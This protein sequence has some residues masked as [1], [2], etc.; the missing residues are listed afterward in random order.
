MSPG[1]LT[2]LVCRGVNQRNATVVV[3]DSL[4]GYLQA[5]PQESFLALEIHQ[6]LSYLNQQRVLTILVTAQHG[7]VGVVESPIDFSYL[8]DAVL[9]LRF[10]EAQG[11]VRKAISV[12]KKRVG[13]HE[14]TI[15][16]LRLTAEGLQVGEPLTD[17]QGIKSGIPTYV[18]SQPMIKAAAGDTHG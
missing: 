4:N 7:L 14:D 1:E 17:F 18:G 2:A 12:L 8:S 6:L 11:K 3:I 10:F 15:R 13:T 16:E 5:M 9:L